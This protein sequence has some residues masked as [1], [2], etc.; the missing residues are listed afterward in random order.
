MKT[1][2]EFALKQRWAVVILSILLMVVGLQTIRNTPLDVFPEFSPLLVE[3]QTEA[4]GLSSTEVESLISIPIENVVNGV[5]GMKIL[6][7]K[8]VQGLSSVVTI[9]DPNTQLM[10][11]RQL[12]QERLLTLSGKLPTQAKAP[13]ILSPLSS[14]SRVLKI[15][16]WSEKMSQTE[17]TT[18]AKW[19]VRPRLMAIPGVANV[20]IWGQRDRQL[21]VHVNPER[22]KEYRLTLDNLIAA[23]KDAVLPASGG[24]LE[25]PN[26]RLSVAHIPAVK[27]ANDL[28]KVPVA[29]RFGTPL[30]LEKVADVTEG[31]QVPIGDA[32]INDQPGLLLIVEKQIGANTLE[33]TKNVEKVMAQLMPAL[34]GI[35]VDTTIFRP[36]TFI[37][38]SIT[39]LNHALIWGCILVAII[40]MSFLMEWRV[41]L[42]SLT[43]IPLSLMTAALV[44]HYQG[45]TM[46]TMIIAGLAIALGEVVDDA[47]IDV[48]NVLRRLRINQAEGN[49]IAAWKVILDASLEVRS[50]VVYA[51]IIVVLVFLPVFFLDGIAGTFFRPL[52]ISYV[53][54]VTASLAVA[55][56]VTPALCLILLPQS[57][58]A[59]ERPEAK[60][61]ISTK[62]SYRRLL[63]WLL[64]HPKKLI[65]GLVIM[66]ILTASSLPFLGEE[67]LPSFKEYDFLMHWVEKP[68]T[69][70][71]ASRKITEKVS[72]ELRAIPGVRN[73]GSHIGRAEVA[74]EVVG[75]NFTELWISVDPKAAYEE[76]NAKIQ[77]VIDGYPGLYRDVL[78][79]L[80]ERIKEVISGGG[81]AVVVRLFGPKVE[82]LRS[83]AHLIE[84]KLS[85][86]EG[87][88][89]LHVEQQAEVPQI[90]VKLKPE[91]AHQVG[92]TA[93]DVRRAAL[94]VIGGVKV[95]EIIEDQKIFDVVVWSSEKS[96]NSLMSLKQILVDTSLGGKVAL[97]EVADLTMGPTPN[98][99]QRENASRKIDISCNVKG[100]D[101]GSVATEIEKTVRSINLGQG[102][103]AELLGEYTA[104]QA[105][106][107]RLIF[108]SLFSLLGIIL[109]LFMD[110]KSV[111]LT[112]LVFISLPFALIGGVISAFLSG[113]VVSL[114]SLVGFVTV[115]GIAAR[116]GVMLI[117]H[118][119]HLH[120]E[121]GHKFDEELILRGA[122]E[123][124]VP[125]L[126]TATATA[127]A[128]F[129]I[130]IG[131]NIPGH[132]IEHPMAVIIVGG[133]ATSTLLNLFVMPVL[134]FYY[135]NEVGS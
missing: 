108:L 114:G 62:A 134:N 107:Q 59:M 11:A 48:E 70:L 105:S 104:R 36:A 35:K 26:Q 95:G 131:G 101:L 5:T 15:G 85:S 71:E 14:M 32:I 117:S 49:K 76:T 19:T 93:G 16:F 88:K 44:L 80:K 79:Y 116:N 75:P 97:G 72:K 120:E 81:G 10:T 50:A 128:L 89:D 4:P 8:S 9:F 47:I 56:I 94:T 127:L 61:V 45:V 20:A 122:E 77:E 103:H 54:S 96:R 55:L 7:S 17:M 24:F 92:V 41:A 87:V 99:I 113:G 46:N 21:Q 74:D 121:E 30:L 1:L 18:L 60:W 82:E 28:K 40:L 109:V 27:T 43:A 102:Y 65:A 42:I 126:M 53:L 86:I 124:L 100:R 38:M 83:K 13:V 2:I 91:I 106:R 112:S 39:N 23:T 51:T 52:A 37:E 29:V 123:R 57:L 130:I 129:P 73:F 98:V 135:G 119:R 63:I 90:E 78:T 34:E 64:D 133:L 125:I 84:E 31:H 12:V 115:L 25:T 132:E 58:H 66:F 111:R 67:F 118:F 69:S 22:M 3:I 110:F 33:V 68:G 6:R